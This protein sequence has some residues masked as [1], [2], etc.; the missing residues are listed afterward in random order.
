[1]L[2][3][4]ER[5]ASFHL[6]WPCSAQDLFSDDPALLPAV[7]PLL[8]ASTLAQLQDP[9]KLSRVFGPEE[10]LFCFLETWSAIVL[11]ERNLRMSSVPGPLNLHVGYCTRASLAP[12]PPPEHLSHKHEIIQATLEDIDAIASFY[13]AFQL[14]APW[15]RVI[16]HADAL[17]LLT[18][19]TN[20]G[21]VFYCR[22]KGRPVAF[23]LV[24]R[25][26][27]R[28]IAVRN[29]YVAKEY[30]RKGMAGAIVRAATRYFLGARPHGIS[31]AVQ[32]TPFVGFK[33]EV[34]LNVA[35]AEAERVYR[36][37]GYMFPDMTN[38][39][40]DDSTGGFDP[41]SGKKAWYASVSR[42][43][44]YKPESEASSD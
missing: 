9:L 17:A 19:S 40:H 26:T 21:L 4:A 18:P 44:E 25:S 2:F 43:L 23:L 20:D 42:N 24:G 28:T 33:E 11:R 22:V 10:I 1:M 6:C 34:S 29:V 37:V 41:V 31:G 15:S 30:R 5:D 14:E 7:L 8:A 39:N 27:P 32:G 36:R 3:K 35:E 13:C 16:P 12:L 38:S